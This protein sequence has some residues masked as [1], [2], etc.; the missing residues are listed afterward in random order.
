MNKIE[1]SRQAG[2]I[3]NSI[4]DPEKHKEFQDAAI[5]AA[6]HGGD[7]PLKLM[8]KKFREMFKTN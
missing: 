2:M 7:N 1:F 4:K 5:Y 6:E 8:P 3:W